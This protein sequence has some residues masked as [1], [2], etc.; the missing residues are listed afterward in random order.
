MFWKKRTPLSIINGRD[1]RNKRNYDV[2]KLAYH[3]SKKE[4]GE[5]MLCKEPQ[6]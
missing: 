1:R 2:N 5:R 4:R 6:P 3:N